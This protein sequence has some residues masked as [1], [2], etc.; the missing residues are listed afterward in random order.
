MRLGQQTRL[1]GTSLFT[2]G[3][4]TILGLFLVLQQGD[5]VR[6]YLKAKEQTWSPRSEFQGR[7]ENDCTTSWLPSSSRIS[8]DYSGKV[9][10]CRRDIA[11]AT[12]EVLSDLWNMTTMSAI[13][14]K[15]SIKLWSDVVSRGVPGD[16]IESFNVDGYS[17]IA[18]AI[19]ARAG[20]VLESCPYKQRRIVWLAGTSEGLLFMNSNDNQLTRDGGAHTI[21]DKWHRLNKT[22]MYISNTL[23]SVGFRQRLDGPWALQSE[24]GCT[25]IRFAE[26]ISQEANNN[27]HPQLLSVLKLNDFSYVPVFNTLKV[28]LPRTIPGAY[29]LVGNSGNLEEASRA[30][31]DVFRQEEGTAPI[32]HDLGSGG[33]WF[34][35]PV[36]SFDQQIT[37]LLLLQ[38]SVLIME[39]NNNDQ[40]ERNFE[41]A[42]SLQTA[43]LESAA[44]H[45]GIQNACVAGFGNGQAAIL[46]LS[47]NPTLTVTTF[48]S[49]ELSEQSIAHEFVSEL[50][51]DRFHWVA[52]Q[53]TK[54]LTRRL[55]YLKTDS[56]KQFDLF[57]VSA[58]SP[59]S[60]TFTSLELAKNLTRVGGFIVLNGYS[61]HFP[62][63]KLAWERSIRESNAVHEIYCAEA[64]PS[65]SWKQLGWCKAQVLAAEERS[66]VK[67]LENSIHIA[68]SVCDMNNRAFEEFKV[69]IK[70][71]LLQID[72][73]VGLI[74]H[75]V[76]DTSTKS[77]IQ[78]WLNTV[79]HL[80]WFGVKYYA[81]VDHMPDMFK[82][83]ATQRLALAE[84][85]P[86]NIEV[87]IYM[88]RDTFVVRN[89][90]DLVKAAESL[91][92][93]TA[94][95]TPEGGRW[96]R[97]KHGLRNRGKTYLA[98]SGLNS[99][100][101]L[102]NLRKMRSNN[103]LQKVLLLAK[104]APFTALGDQ[105][106][107]NL[108]FAQR[109]EEVMMMSCRF[110][111][112]EV[113]GKTE[114]DYGME[115][116]YPVVL[117]GNRGA[118]HRK[119]RTSEM[120]ELWSCM[121]QLLLCRIDECI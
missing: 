98:P 62:I 105:D 74:L 115:M 110:N 8:T 59:N 67:Q 20:H 54:P 56:A 15:Q 75:I 48:Q 51:P 61:A 45:R 117:H 68:V 7:S 103:F 86:R 27:R 79:L 16:W 72:P 66:S 4:A 84:L 73:A 53:S 46:L 21:Q 35:R 28:L 89:F 77:L 113:L 82:R 13:D 106:I 95:L 91:G 41:N 26:H 31:Q 70:S 71:L 92:N 11:T 37:R 109:P 80:V 57:Y 119:G 100:V 108:Y 102:M 43:S 69:L 33:Y 90:N 32:L 47:S 121:N 38:A 40:G 99:G 97:K 63:I 114:C 107:L 14:T 5:A 81:A 18:A 9:A 34:R 85:L 29:I 104:Q 22:M 93:H 78:S 17:S 12:R 64:V 23:V 88:D 19:I 50:F 25:E 116:V 101:M 1:S 65:Q 30:A 55:P 76:V 6:R 36:S 42:A 94:A 111:F 52:S 87:L 39:H 96:Y 10:A 83:C 118:F 44:Q 58:E 60:T 2:H 3:T 49:L 120:L 24:T 112:R